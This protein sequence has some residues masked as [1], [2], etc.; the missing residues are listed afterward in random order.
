MRWQSLHVSGHAVRSITSADE[1]ENFEIQVGSQQGVSTSEA[2]I[3][4]SRDGLP[5]LEIP[6][7]PA[8]A[9]EIAA[10]LIRMADVCEENDARDAREVNGIPG[11][12]LT[13]DA[14]ELAAR[15]H[16]SSMIERARAV[17]GHQVV[18]ITGPTGVG[19]TQLVAAM[20]N[21]TPGAARLD[22][23]WDFRGDGWDPEDRGSTAWIADIAPT[24]VLDGLD[25]A[26]KPGALAPEVLR[27]VA[28]V[29]VTRHQRRR[30]IIVC[31]TAGR[32]AFEQTFGP[33]ATRVVFDAEAR[34]DLDPSYRFPVAE[35]VR[36]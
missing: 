7:S 14:P 2:L 19:K 17:L 18:T 35:E 12:A 28:D 20:M 13:F 23:T 25:V 11:G 32:A 16:P 22:Y 15:V 6:L 9:R 36:F 1:D 4:L 21:A 34:I 27:R 29:I 33:E 8:D 5:H 31:S 24:L 3:T 30:P 26:F 10:R